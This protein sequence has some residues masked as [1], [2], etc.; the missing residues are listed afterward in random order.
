[1]FAR[2]SLLEPNFASGE[3]D[4][5]PVVLR[6]LPPPTPPHSRLPKDEFDLSFFDGLGL[7]GEDAEAA[8]PQAS[9]ARRTRKSSVELAGETKSDKINR[10]L[11]D[12][13]DF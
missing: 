5:E 4:D 12:L 13:A 7:G 1:M 6:D 3:D 11:S 8:K 10:L 9:A 2:S